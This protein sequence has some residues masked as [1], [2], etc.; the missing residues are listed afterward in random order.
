NLTITRTFTA[1]DACNNSSTCSQL[2]TVQ[3]QNNPALVSCPA[4]KT[5]N[6]TADTSVAALGSATFTGNCGSPVTVTSADV[7]T[8]NADPNNCA[9]YTY[10]I[11]RTFTAK[12]ACNNS[13]T[14]SQL[15][16][17]QD[18]NNPVL[19]SCPGD[20]TVNCTADTSVAAMGSATF[21]GSCGSPVTV[22]S[23]DESTQSAN[24]TDCAHY[25]YTITRTFTAK[26]ACN[27]S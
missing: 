16:T 5:V 15:I 3:D 22:T 4:D 21:T 9:H 23:A 20:K 19:V 24:P 6:C 7:S 17:V 11:T 10:T 8:Q 2:I 14:C 13:S 12:D 18:Q 25:T 26:D 1:K 27:N